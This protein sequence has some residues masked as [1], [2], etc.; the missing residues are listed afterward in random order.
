MIYFLLL[1]D[2][3]VVVR[4]CALDNGAATKD[5]E[6]GMLNHCGWSKILFSGTS[7]KGCLMTCE[8]D[9]CNGSPTSAPSSL[10]GLLATCILGIHFLT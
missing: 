7:M 4:D 2:Y 3:T 5:G 8:T 1:D 10:I 9:G 6:I